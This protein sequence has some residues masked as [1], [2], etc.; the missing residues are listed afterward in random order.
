VLKLTRR[1]Q[2]N[3]QRLSSLV[4]GQWFNCFV[5]NKFKPGAPLFFLRRCFFCVCAQW[6][7]VFF[8][9][10]LL[11]FCALAPNHKTIH[12]GDPVPSDSNIDVRPSIATLPHQ[13][14]AGACFYD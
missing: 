1:W 11:F 14:T 7:G 8:V 12:W 4:L 13:C 5:K 3:K 2:V 9:A 6:L 10:E